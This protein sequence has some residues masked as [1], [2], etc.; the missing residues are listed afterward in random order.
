MS[1]IYKLS[2]VKAVNSRGEDL[3]SHFSNFSSLYFEEKRTA[4]SLVAFLE[5]IKKEGV[6]F[7]WEGEEIHILSH[8]EAQETI[9]DCLI[10]PKS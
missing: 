2:L 7:V 8:Q 10:K 4:N 5:E 9:I 1:T 6:K 3:T